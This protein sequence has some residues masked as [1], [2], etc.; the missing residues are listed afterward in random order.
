M[1]AMYVNGEKIG[2]LADAERLLPE[3]LARKVH[4]EL[5][6]D[7]GHALAE[8]RPIRRESLVPWAP[9]VTREELTRRLAGPRVTREGATKWMGWE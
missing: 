4:V 9:A 5:R 3:L 7:S 1:V 6:D 2:T 8:V